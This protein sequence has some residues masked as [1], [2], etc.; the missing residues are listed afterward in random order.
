MIDITIPGQPFVQK[1]HRPSHRGG[2][3][4]PSSE[5][6]KTIQWQLRAGNVKPRKPFTVSLMIEIIAYFETP[7]S[8][9][10]KK[11]REHEGQY[12]P[13]TPDADNIFKIY[14][15]AMNNYIY[16]D[17]AQIVRSVVEKRYSTEPRTV[18]KI[19]GV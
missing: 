3:Y 17:D 16:E 7:K 1:R 8:W 18:I 15:D 11:K 6:K 12:R 9:S 13:K 19:R 4:D 5:D 10:K 14:A 2:Y